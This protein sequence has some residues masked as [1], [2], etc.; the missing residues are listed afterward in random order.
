MVRASWGTDGTF[1]LG[2]HMVEGAR[3]SG[4]SLMRAPIPSS[5][6]IEGGHEGGLHPH[7]LI[8]PKAPLPDTITLGIRFQH[9]NVRGQEHSDHSRS[10]HNQKFRLTCMCVTG[11]NF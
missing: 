8:T 11:G 4:V 9:M 3:S 6:G 2:P 1:S 10:H 5:V 7:D